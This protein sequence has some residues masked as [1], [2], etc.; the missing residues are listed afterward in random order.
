MFDRSSCKLLWLRVSS[1]HNPVFTGAAALRPTQLLQSPPA[2]HTVTTRA[3]AAA[4]AAA[5]CLSFCLSICAAL[6]QPSIQHSARS[7]AQTPHCRSASGA[8]AA[9]SS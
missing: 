4:A 1:R 6:H 2:L 9:G 8:A 7:P 5:V 3:A